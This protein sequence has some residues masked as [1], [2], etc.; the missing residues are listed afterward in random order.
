MGEG[1]GKRGVSVMAYEGLYLGISC[2]PTTSGRG[3]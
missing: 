3:K 1:G 2:I